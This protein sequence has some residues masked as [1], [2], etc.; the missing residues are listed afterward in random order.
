MV[1][2]IRVY[3]T[4]SSNVKQRMTGRQFHRIFFHICTVSITPS[5]PLIAA[6]FGLGKKSVLEIKCYQWCCRNLHYF[7]N[8][9][10]H[11]LSVSISFCMCVC[12][13]TIGSFN[14]KVSILQKFG[15]TVG[16]KKLCKHCLFYLFHRRGVTRRKMHT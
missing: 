1:I 7:V 6:L 10:A 2:C 11:I 5:L 12:V 9:T 13:C 4:S 15:T 3:T 8:L 14:G 16:G